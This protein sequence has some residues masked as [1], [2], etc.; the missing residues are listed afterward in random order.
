MIVLLPFFNV[1]FT[2]IFIVCMF[3]VFA[4]VLLSVDSAWMDVLRMVCVEQ[5]IIT[6]YLL[7]I[8]LQGNG[9]LFRFFYSILIERKKCRKKEKIKTN[10]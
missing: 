1:F 2:L 9:K 10:A 3:K 7:Q 5:P 6:Y 8:L 4:C